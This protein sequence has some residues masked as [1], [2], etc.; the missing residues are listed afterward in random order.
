MSKIVQTHTSIK[1]RTRKALQRG[2]SNVQ[3]AIGILVTVILLLGALSGY[4]YIQQ[5]KVNNE[6]GALTD[7]K[8]ATVSLGQAGNFP[9][10]AG[11]DTATLK[12]MNFFENSAFD[13]SAGVKNQWGGDVTGSF[14]KT[15]QITITS[16]SV[17]ASVCR[18]IFPKIRTIVK[19]ASVGQTKVIV[20]GVLTV[21]NVG[22]AC[23]TTTVEMTY[24]FSR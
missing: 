18:E 16:A 14:T 5:A 15:D 7:I 4:Q 23:G 3:I 12:G 8:A 10:A 19:D 21:A 24:V 13:T 17:P 2:F 22:T 11:T 1:N 20:D 6:I 9:A